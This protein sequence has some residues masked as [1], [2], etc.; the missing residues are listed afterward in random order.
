MGQTSDLLERT[1][2]ERGV[3]SRYEIRPAAEEARRSDRPLWRVLL[4]RGLVQE[5]DLADAGVEIGGGVSSGDPA[6]G[7]P[8]AAPGLTPAPVGG[9]PTPQHQASPSGQ[10]AGPLSPEDVG[11]PPGAEPTEGRGREPALG[12]FLEAVI[13]RGGSDLHLTTGVPPAIRVHGDLVH[14]EGY[15]PLEAKD[16]Q[17]IVYSMISQR[18]RQTFEE[19]L[20][21]DLSYSLPGRARFRVNVFQQRDAVGAVMR[22]IPHELKSLAALGLPPAV[23][24]FTRLRR[25][26]VLVTGVTG[27]GKSTTLASLLDM[28]NDT[29]PEHIMTV[30]DPIEFLHRHKKAIINQREVGTDTHGF[31]NALKHVL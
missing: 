28:I 1:L 22:L 10:Q 8:P 15:R 6:F 17:A 9:P 7:A 29:R 16:L 21:L 26:L 19:N 31:A 5:A 18:Q 20:E 3:V 25:G 2:V 14:L 4:E 23:A 13:E 12:E 27:S 30:E 24:E 11:A